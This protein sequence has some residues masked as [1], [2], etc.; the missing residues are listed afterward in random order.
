MIDFNRLIEESIEELLNESSHEQREAVFKSLFDNFFNHTP[1]RALPDI[2]KRI[3]D[4][5]ARIQAMCASIRFKVSLNDSTITII[6]D[7]QDSDTLLR[8]ALGTDWFE[9]TDI[10]R[11]ILESLGNTSS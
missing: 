4:T 7:P 10:G 9:G 5:G 1:K 8:L 6:A 11:A 3:K 2:D